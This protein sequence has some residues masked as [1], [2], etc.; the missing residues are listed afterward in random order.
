MVRSNNRARSNP[1]GFRLTTQ[2]I[3]GCVGSPYTFALT[4]MI[5]NHKIFHR[6]TSYSSHTLANPALNNSDFVSATQ[7]SK[8]RQK[9]FC[10]ERHI[11]QL[12]TSL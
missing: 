3:S 8:S 5:I 9:R 11:N 2:T 10:Q 1:S 12:H 4:N 6:P 7:P